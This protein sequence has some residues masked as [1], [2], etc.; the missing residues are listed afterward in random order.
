MADRSLRLLRGLFPYPGGKRRLTS[1]LF[2]ILAEQFPRARWPGTPLLDPMCGAGA[3]ALHAK[4]YG[5]E[6]TAADCA[7]RGVIPARA[8]VANSTAR[9]TPAHVL[10]LLRG[11]ES[12]AG[13][14]ADFVPTVFSAAEARWI[15]G[16]LVVARGSAE[17]WRSLLLQLIVKAVLRLKPIEG[18][19]HAILPEVPLNHSVQVKVTFNNGQYWTSD[20][21]PQHLRLELTQ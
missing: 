8:L 12:L 6:V 16:A 3:F 20:F 13:A 2:A 15:D 11:E 9:L 1:S 7:Q 18:G 17:P 21:M 10:P 4:A 14:A 19:I 5:F